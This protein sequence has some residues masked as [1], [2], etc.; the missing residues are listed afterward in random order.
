MDVFAISIHLRTIVTTP[1]TYKDQNDRD[2]IV[3]VRSTNMMTHL[4]LEANMTH[5]ILKR[6]NMYF[7]REYY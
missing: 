5:L 1:H 2:M 3:K 7:V 6:S 4:V